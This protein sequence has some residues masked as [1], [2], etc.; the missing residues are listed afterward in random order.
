MKTENLIPDPYIEIGFVIKTWGNRGH[1]K[2][3]PSGSDPDRFKKLREI[4]AVRNGG[5]IGQ[6]EVEETRFLSGSVVIKLKMIDTPEKAQYLLNTFICVDE[7]EAVSLAPWEFFIHQ[8]RGMTV[9][10]IN[11][12]SIGT[13]AEIWE[14]GAHDIYRILTDSGREILI[15]A[16]R[17]I[18]RDI[19]VE[20]RVIAV[21]CPEGMLDE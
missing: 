13:V 4:A 12:G 20:G 19:D 15:P 6:F 17:S 21:D 18:I 11:R 10:D 3:K 16:V 7:K 8:I 5:V 2:I 1:L 14:I 9:V